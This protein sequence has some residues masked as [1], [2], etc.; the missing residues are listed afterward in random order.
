MYLCAESGARR[1]VALKAFWVD[2]NHPGFCVFH[3]D[4]VAS[5]NDAEK[6]RGLDVQIPFEQRAALPSGSYFVT[7]LIGAS[8]F[9]LPATPSPV[10]SSPCSAPEVPSLLGTVRDV[11]RRAASIGT[12]EERYSHVTPLAESFP[13]RIGTIDP[14][15]VNLGARF[16]YVNSGSDIEHQW[17][18]GNQ[19]QVYR[20]RGERDAVHAEYR[21]F[22][23]RP[24]RSIGSVAARCSG[25]PRLMRVRIVRSSPFKHLAQ[26]PIV[27]RTPLTTIHRLRL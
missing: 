19:V 12:V 16:A 21:A 23:P 8:V 4:G 25:H 10:T 22:P 9:E 24:S 17:L 14:G 13:L 11:Y 7:D 5:I 6:L 1:G 18:I 20:V 26:S 2:R 3:F 27:L 15:S